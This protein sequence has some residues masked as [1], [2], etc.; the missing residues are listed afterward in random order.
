MGQR[1]RLV[2]K[3]AD[4]HILIVGVVVDAHGNTVHDF[5]GKL[6]N[7][8]LNWYQPLYSCVSAIEASIKRVQFKV[9]GTSA[10]SNLIIQKVQSADGTTRTWGVENTGRSIYELDPLWGLVS[11]D[12]TNISGISALRRSYLYLRAAGSSFIGSGGSTTVRDSIAGAS[13]PSTQL[14]TVYGFVNRDPDLGGSITFPDYTGATTWS[15]FTNWSR[16]SRNTST[17]GHIPNLIWT[18][19]MANA[20]IGTKSLLSNSTRFQYKRPAA[21]YFQTVVYNWQYA[22]FALAFAVM[23]I[24]LLLWSLLLSATRECNFS[25]LRFFLNQSSA[26]RTMT[27]ERFDATAEDDLAVTSI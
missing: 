5:D 22:G 16:L 25:M 17:A 4:C 27:T 11:A 2:K 15:L 14:D 8:N 21:P 1:C 24:M 3:K 6:F 13:A 12:K 23:Y 19:L 20:V 18:D 7:P 26:G 9:N 10:L